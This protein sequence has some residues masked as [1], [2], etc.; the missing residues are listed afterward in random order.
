MVLR[1]REDSDLDII[2]VLQIQR[3]PPLIFYYEEKKKSIPNRDSICVLKPCDQNAVGGIYNYIRKI[4]G[5]WLWFSFTDSLVS[6][7]PNSC[8]YSSQAGLLTSPKWY[9]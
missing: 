1:E 4:R 9:H 2:I 5:K 8:V 6:F 7:L 3:W